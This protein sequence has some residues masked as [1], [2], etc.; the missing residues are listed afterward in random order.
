MSETLELNL[1]DLRKRFL[2]GTSARDAG[3]I[4][5][6]AR[7]GRNSWDL[8]KL[9]RHHRNGG[10]TDSTE[11]DLRDSFDML[12]AFYGLVEI[13]SII[14]YVP[15]PLPIEF[16]R[17]ARFDLS[18]EVVLKYYAVN[19]PLLLPQLLRRRLDSEQALQESG[20]QSDLS[21]ATSIFSRFLGLEERFRRESDL[22]LLLRLLDSFY[23]DDYDISD[24]VAA[25]RK[26]KEFMKRL[27]KKPRDRDVLD[28]ALQGFVKLLAF[29]WELDA[30][31]KSAERF[32]LLQSTMWHYHAYS[33]KI[34]RTEF[35][36]NINSAVRS[37][38]SWSLPTPSKKGRKE[39]QEYVRVTTEIVTRLTS[40][41]YGRQMVKFTP[42]H[43]SAESVFTVF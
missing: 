13:A 33:F 16:Q 38:S 22:E 8:R 29:C 19:Y 21:Q 25:V 15:N 37:F 40:D 6:N 14:A 28:D 10:V 12:L 35:T 17:V 32:L 11:I 27:T 39:I 9:L 1:Y 34:I 7:M 20:S 31:L 30:L 24:V 41:Q 4:L 42:P 5:Q 26:P 3:K 36:K 18:Q 2:L 23:F 43:T